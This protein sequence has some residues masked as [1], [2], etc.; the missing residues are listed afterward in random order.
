MKDFDLII[1]FKAS[2]WRSP[3]SHLPYKVDYRW[4]T[5]TGDCGSITAR[6]SNGMKI[7]PGCPGRPVLR[8]WPS[9]RNWGSP[10]S[11]EVG[12]V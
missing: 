4:R 1:K 5:I 7:Y 8:W 2:S 12:R 9:V 10:E 11:R 6:H 3:C